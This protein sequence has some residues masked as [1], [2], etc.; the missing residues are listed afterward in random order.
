MANQPGLIQRKGVFYVQKRVPTA[1]VDRAGKAIITKS[2]KTRDRREATRR[3]H[4]EMQQIEAYFD[5]LRHGKTPL[6]RTAVSD[7]RAQRS[8]A[9]LVAEHVR[10]LSNAEFATRVAQFELAASDPKGFWKGVHFDLPDTAFFDHLVEEGE[11]DRAI[12]YIARIRLKA[13]IAD[14]RRM[15]ATGD[16]RAMIDRAKE[17]TGTSDEGKARVLARVLA[18]AEIDALERI[19]V[20]ETDAGASEPPAPTQPL[21]APGPVTAPQAQGGGPLL[22]SVCDDWLQEKARTGRWVDKTRNEREASV[23]AFIEVCGDRPVAAYGKSDVK[24]F[25]DVLF[26][27]PPNAHKMLP[28]KG[29]SLPALA[30]RAQQLGYPGPSAKNVA[31]KMDAVSSLFIW[32]RKNFD[33]VVTNPFEGMKPEIDSAPREE[34]DPFSVEEL[35]RIFRTPPYSGARSEHFWLQAG[36]QVLSH[37]GRYW[38]PIIAA[39]SGMR[40][41]EIVQLRKEDIRFSDEICYFDINAEGD[42]R[43]KTRSAK[44]RIPVHPVLVSLGFLDFVA[45]AKHP[46]HRIFPDVDIGPHQNPSAPASR[47][48]NRLIVEAGVKSRKNCF[49]SFRHSFEDACRNAEID[50]AVM[51]ALQGHA[52]GGMSGRYGRGFTL[53]RLAQ[54][55]RRIRYG[56]SLEAPGAG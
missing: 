8:F 54:A 29:L 21:P 47:L 35:E 27:I 9:E 43:L 13:R 45:R 32:A 56:L 31:L 28:F 23:R 33:E 53:D 7:P 15:L 40:L 49:H 44:R 51:N 39:Y 16:L 4:A 26:Q 3:L 10:A 38:I 36:D 37:M 42:K 24:R 11:L 25:K 30:A 52:E 6:A 1:L 5:S 34:R 12:A 2:L 46:E 22:S 55:V 50:W 41:M 48:F 19:L 14:L 17:M 18:R 20:G